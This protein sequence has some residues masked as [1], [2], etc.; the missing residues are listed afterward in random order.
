MRYHEFRA[1]ST[2]ILLAA[3]GE[4][5]E[6]NTAFEQTQAYV[7][8]SERR[9]TRFSETS[10]LADLNRSAGT[11]FD[12]SPEMYEVLSLAMR[13]HHRFQALFDPA[14]LNALEM[15]GYD[16]S[17][18]EVRARDQASHKEAAYGKQ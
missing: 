14:I 3:E 9:F 18:E 8:A 17:I 7:E 5:D 16:R 6:L 4:P 1:M 15:A 13:F 10:E 2:D 11:W 12:T